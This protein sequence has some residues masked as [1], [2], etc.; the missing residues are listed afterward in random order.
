MRTR[1]DRAAAGFADADFLKRRAAEDAVARL[2]AIMREFP[3]AV[4]L[5][6]RNGAFRDALAESDAQARV[7]FL[8]EA[9]LSSKMLAGR[10]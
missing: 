5:G 1:L 2:E 10:G 3:L 9:D 7:G 6:S 8:I 4:D